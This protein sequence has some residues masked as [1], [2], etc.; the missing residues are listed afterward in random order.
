MPKGDPC[1]N[2]FKNIYIENRRYLEQQ[3][4]YFYNLN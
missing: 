3:I 4:L 2:F 1:F